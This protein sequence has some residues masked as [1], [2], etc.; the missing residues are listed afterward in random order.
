MKP[1]VKN[2]AITLSANTYAGEMYAEYNTKS[3]LPDTGIGARGLVTV[4][5][6]NKDKKLMRTVEQALEFKNP[7]AAFTAQNGALTLGEKALEV[8]PYE[9]H[10]QTDFELLR[11]TWESQTLRPGSFNDYL[12]TPELSNFL[13]SE[14][15][16]PQLARMNEQMYI[17][18][19]GGVNVKGGTATISAAYPGILATL[20]AGADVV[21]FELSG[22]DSAVRTI[23]DI[24][25][26]AAGSA[27][28][29][30]GSTT[31]IKVG[32]EITILGTNGNQQIG[33]TTI[34]G[35]T[36]SVLQVVNTT[37][38]RV[39]KAITGDTA[40][41]QG[42]IQF[43]NQ[44]NVIDVL[45]YNY[46]LVPETE[47]LKGDTRIL[48]PSKVEKYY[49]QA[50]AAL[51]NGSGEY[52]RTGYFGQS[53]IPFLDM[54]IESMPF[55]APNTIA[56]WNKDNVFLDVDLISDD[57]NIKISYQGDTTLDEVYRMRN[58]MKSNIDYL[59]GEQILFMRPA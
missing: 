15:Y 34:V 52:T 10:V 4:R 1:N 40:T 8:V 58:R 23:T 51:A 28:V 6:D 17:L 50:N 24:T 57:V 56:T 55:W 2:T 21:K 36:V 31:D 47:R 5:E 41:D 3:L 18:G 32:D 14:I 9:V 45:N 39:N 16:Q 19:K 38:L 11:T 25:T 7:S 43:I 26:A 29:V 48:V 46:A 54:T 27:T 13:M 20:E 59:F 12:G 37:T 33:G 35:Q 44:A 30:V 53:G 49:R 42:T 22:V